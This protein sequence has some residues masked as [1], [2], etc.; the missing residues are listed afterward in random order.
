M[1]ES[2]LPT[3]HGT[4]SGALQRR[5]TRGL[6][7]TII[8]AWGRQLLGLVVFVVL[9]RLLDPVDFGLVALAAVF[10][11]FVQILVDQGLGDALVQRRELTRAHI[12]TAFWVSLTTGAV[13]A[14]VGIVLAI[15]IAAFLG[16]PALQPLLQVL[17]LTFVL[18]ALNSVQVALLRRE[19]AFRSLALRTLVA[20]AGGGAVG[21]TLAYLDFGP[22]ALVGQQLGQAVLAVLVLWRTSPWRP[23]RQVSRTHFRELFS[24]GVH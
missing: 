19:L 23:T 18:T 11:A 1:S 10:V 3:E 21:I 22:W 12:D 20:I 16:Q 2:W 6:T 13:L 8:D 14:V 5:V 9:T 4:E 24:F 7:W 17:S 15:P